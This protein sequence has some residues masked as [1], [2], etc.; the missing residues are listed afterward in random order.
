M[1]LTFASASPTQHD[2]IESILRTAFTP[3]FQKLGYEL[4]GN[5]YAWL[6]PAIEMGRVYVGLK[7]EEIVGVVVTNRH[8]N[9]L[10][11]EYIAI[12]PDYQGAG[13]GSW[14]IARIEDVARR[15]SVQALVLHTPEIREDLL[16]L[17]H[18]QGFVETRRALPAHGKDAHLRIHMRKVI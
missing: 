11:I 4:T 10:E 3:Y 18:R 16:R 9:E 5:V 14:L 15:D 2:R 1:K 8:S 12:C 13:I 6:Q 17:Y 7:G